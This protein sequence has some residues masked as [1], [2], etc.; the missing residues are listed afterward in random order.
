MVVSSNPLL[1]LK[2]NDFWMSRR[3][4]F[5]GKACNRKTI[6][7]YLLFLFKY[8]FS[9]SYNNLITF[10]INK[11]RKLKNLPCYAK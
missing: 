5:I 4:L 10:N 9:Q 11:L 6:Y 3:S 7:L 2:T 1:V 8:I